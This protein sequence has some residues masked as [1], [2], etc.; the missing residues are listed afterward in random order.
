V[1]ITRA[2]VQLG[3]DAVGR[4]LRQTLVVEEVSGRLQDAVASSHESTTVA[5]LRRRPER[6]QPLL[7]VRDLL[8]HSGE[9]H[10]IGKAQTPQRR[11]NALVEDILEGG[12]GRERT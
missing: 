1:K 7:Q 5:S 4:N 3:G 9:F 10:R 11:G 8:A 6:L 12:Q 2:D